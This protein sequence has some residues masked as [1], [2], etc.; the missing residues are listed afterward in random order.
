VPV[1]KW[2]VGS[3]H[4]T[5]AGNWAVAP[6][7][8]INPGYF[9]PRAERELL[10]A[11]ADRRWAEVSRTQRVLTWQLMG[12]G[13]LPP[14]WADVNGSGHAVP[15]APPA[16]GPVH[17]G[18]DAARLP[19]RFAESC[20]SADRAL[21][22]SMRPVLATPG[23][24]PALRNLDGSGASDWQHPVAIVSAAA[25]EQAAGDADAA[26]TRLDE[27]TTLQQ[28]YPTYFGAA[29]VALGRIMLATTLLGDCPAQGSRFVDHR[30][31]A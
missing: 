15:V 6:K 10:H 7:Q 23:D 13:E 30:Q 12:S 31:P 25:A 26:A 27:A 14:D 2:V 16:G 22:A 5:V 21:A 29:W 18:L 19:I 17:F 20:D 24:V 8:S 4:T 11:S 9:S 28:Q 1:G 3:G